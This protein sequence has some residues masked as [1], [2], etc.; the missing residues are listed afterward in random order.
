MPR[1]R[2]KVTVQKCVDPAIIFDGKVPNMP[3]KDEPYKKCSFEEGRTWIVEKNMQMPDGFCGWA[4]RDL[5]KDLSV[6]VMG[7]NFDPWV[8]KGLIYTSCSD[9]I[10]PVS[11]KL[12]R[13]ED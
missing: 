1:N 13:L 12:E 9:G 8:E 4:W 2:V 3:G 6:M 11:F 5:Y 10:R 7:G